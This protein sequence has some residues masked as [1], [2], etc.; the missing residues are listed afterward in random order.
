MKVFLKKF[1]LEINLFVRC[2]HLL[3]QILPEKFLDAL[4]IDQI[5][6]KTF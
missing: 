5:L 1:N 6:K 4:I 3:A 2:T